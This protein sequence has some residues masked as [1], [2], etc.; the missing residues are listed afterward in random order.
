V[1]I[2]D[3]NHET[4]VL[5]NN[6]INLN[7]RLVEKLNAINPNIQYMPYK[8]WCIFNFD[9]INKGGNRHSIKVLHHHGSGGASPVSRGSIGTNRRAVNYP[10]A[11]IFVTGHSHQQYLI[12]IASEGITQMGQ[13]TNDVGFHICLG[14]YKEELEKGS[15]FAVE[16]GLNKKTLGGAIVELKYKKGKVKAFPRL[17]THY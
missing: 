9:K 8:Y 6:E 17:I 10:D 7:K 4:A 1:A 2:G 12:P 16:K 11:D 15:G 3:G 13:P 14:T 5:K